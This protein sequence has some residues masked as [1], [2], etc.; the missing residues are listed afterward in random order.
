M[1][2]ADL[3]PQIIKLSIFFYVLSLYYVLKL[4]SVI[5]PHFDKYFE[6][7]SNA[8]LKEQR[9]PSFEKKFET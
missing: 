6:V 3:T 8:H 4:Y 2:N 1:A 5:L 9:R 7:K